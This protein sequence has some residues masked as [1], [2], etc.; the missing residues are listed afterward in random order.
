MSTYKRIFV[1]LLALA[2]VVASIPVYALDAITISTAQ[3]FLEFSRLCK[4]DGYSQGKTVNL[5]ADLDLT[6]LEFEDIPIFLGTF[7]GN[8]HTISGV[9]VNLNKDSQGLFR[10]ISQEAVVADLHVEGTRETTHSTVGGIAA[11]NYGTIQN[12]SYNGILTGQDMV[13]GIVGDNQGTIINCTTSGGV[14]GENNI[15]GIAGN[16]DGAITS[17]RNEAQINTDIASFQFAFEDQ[18]LSAIN[19]YDE[20]VTNIGGIAGA[21]QGAVE[22]STNQGAVG[23]PHV[24]YNVGG[25]AGLQS[26]YISGCVNQA[27]VL[28]RME[29]GGIV[30]QFEPY[31]DT[32][33]STSKLQT[34]REEMELLRDLTTNL[35][36]N[37]ANSSDL[38]HDDVSQFGDSLDES[39]THVESLLDQTEEMVNANL[40]AANEISD[41]VSFTLDALVPITDSLDPV[42]DSL[43]DSMA[44][45]EEGADH[46][47]QASEA[48][49]GV[50]DILDEMST[51]FDGASDSIGDALDEIQDALILIEDSQDIE[52]LGGH[53]QDLGDHLESA[54]ADLQEANAYLGSAAVIADAY[55]AELSADIED[56]QTE[57]YY[58]NVALANL[59]AELDEVSTALEGGDYLSSTDLSGLVTAMSDVSDS[60]GALLGE[61]ESLENFG[62][63]SSQVFYYLGLA[64]TSTD[65]ALGSIELAMGKVSDI[66]G[67]IEGFAQ[68]AQEVAGL[69]A[70]AMDDFDDAR[71]DFEQAM[72]LA[73]ELVDILEDANGSAK[74]GLDCLRDG[75]G[76]LNDATT[77]LGTTQDLLSDLVDALSAKD[78]IQFTK[79]DEDF[80]ATRDQLSASLEQMSTDM[81][82]LNDTIHANGDILIDDAEA[83]NQQFS[84]VADLI[85]EIL[86]DATSFIEEETYK[87]EDI[88]TWN[89]PELLT[90]RVTDCQNLGA[91]EGDSHVGGIAGG[92]SFELS[93][94]LED[95]WLTDRDKT[96][97]ITR[98]GLAIIQ[99]SLSTGDVT[100]K[101]DGAGGIVGY[102]DFG[103][104][105]HCTAVSVVESLEGGYVGGIAGQSLAII[106]QC[107]GKTTLTGTQFL[108]GIAGAGYDIQNSYS[109]ATIT[110]TEG[111]VGGI[112]GDLDEAGTLV[113]N[114]FVSDTLGGLDGIS[115]AGQAEAISYQDLLLVE[116]L[117]QRFFSMSLRFFAD[118]VLIAT[119]TV[120]YGGDFDLARLPEP[121]AKAGYFCQWE[122]LDLTNITGDLKIHGTYYPVRTTIR[123][124]LE[125][126]GL[127]VFLVDG[128]FTDLETLVVT[129]L[130]SKGWYAQYSL[131]VDGQAT[132][133]DTLR[134][135][136][137]ESP[138]S[139]QLYQGGRWVNASYTVDG[140]YLHIPL[141]PGTTDVELRVSEQLVE[142]HTLVWIGLGLGLVCLIVAIRLIKKRRPKQTASTEATIA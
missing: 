50:S 135:L 98:Q 120:D 6:G 8:D 23:Y 12:C 51:H 17:C 127:A 72:D 59:S 46:F 33:Y 82:R 38:I 47:S 119:E 108:G 74:D 63:A 36:D 61:L 138:V 48:L 107:Y 28:G 3:E 54:S 62:T 32:I 105:E 115:F 80:D 9:D 26:G 69:L 25:I 58:L 43:S 112:V 122:D 92:I 79:F 95:S 121:P 140:K 15:G 116:G 109:L 49:E 86:Q 70:D 132:T 128:T 19:P 96:Q 97:S 44:A 4:Y 29:V 81:E 7:Y 73:E 64:Q 94:D 118:D 133:M 111:G 27:Q 56:A 52:N 84:L 37:G 101:K 77:D 1:L 103:L 57:I 5:T 142:H 60:L 67:D 2:L 40:D 24:G 31:V 114:Y 123:G 130:E 136:A 134:Y 137:P 104:V 30:G 83:I 68:T 139:I 87:I 22:S 18:T 85:V 129:Q 89:V 20:T 39:K 11:V 91:V 55:L 13:G 34:L 124:N 78:D 10:H 93:F 42:L 21:N 76:H 125:Q 117:D 102:Q 75:F 126:D 99:N 113:N 41:R 106:R 110:A 131:H 35:T 141:E 45:M 53:I 65:S 66:G 71:Y 88:S 14:F 90:G 100:A 16:N